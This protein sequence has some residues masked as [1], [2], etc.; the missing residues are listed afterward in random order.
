MSNRK[1]KI[2]ESRLSGNSSDILA[3]KK[4][5]PQWQKDAD[6]KSCYL[7]ER[8]FD[9]F[10]RK[11]HCRNCGKIICDDC[12]QYYTSKRARDPDRVCKLCYNCVLNS[13]G[14]D[15]DDCKSYMEQAKL[16]D[17]S[18]KQFIADDFSIDG[19]LAPKGSILTII[20]HPGIDNMERTF[21]ARVYDRMRI[22][23]IISMNSNEEDDGGIKLTITEISHQ[24]GFDFKVGD[25]I[26]LVTLAEGNELLQYGNPPSRI[27]VK[28]TTKNDDGTSESTGKGFA[29]V[30]NVSYEE[31]EGETEIVAS[32]GYKRRKNK[33]KRKN[34]HS[35][36]RRRT[37]KR[38][39]IHRK[40][41]KVTK[42]LRKSRRHARR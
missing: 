9:M 20:N 40:N 11:H 19:K 38:S 33:S 26:Y 4:E 18:V 35:V 30:T 28:K 7:C 29:I 17:E 1:V 41:K 14:K 6:V 32:G 15:S 10:T 27:L 5:S 31:M 13:E 2:P 39:N 3:L 24:Y 34:K 16:V 42:R 23:P 37:S 8:K 21:K 12:S 22:N 36:R 25:Q